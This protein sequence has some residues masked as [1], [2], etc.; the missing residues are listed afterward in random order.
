[1]P[2]AGRYSTRWRG[3]G[4]N[5]SPR[6]GW[7]LPVVLSVVLAAGA[8]SSIVPHDSAPPI[9]L[10]ATTTPWAGSFDSVDLPLPVNSITSVSCPTTSSCW[11]T[12]ST[13]GGGGNPLGAVILVTR[14]GGATWTSDGIPTTIGYLSS[15]SCRDTTHCVAVGE[16]TTALGMEGVALMDQ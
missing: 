4:C 9:G 5:S 16:T 14:N 2:R 13:E 6:R 10:I 3:P 11:A 15:I 8:C 1:M 12:G 7:T